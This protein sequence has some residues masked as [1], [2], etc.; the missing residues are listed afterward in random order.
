MQTIVKR[1]DLLIGA[2]A[3]GIA[4]T[5]SPARGAPVAM[6]NFSVLARGLMA[7][8]GPKPQADG[9]VLVVEMARGTL[10][11]VMPDHSVQVVARLGGSPNG[12]AIGPDGAAYV[13][14]DGGFAFAKKNGLWQA[15]GT[16]PHYIGGSIQR[17][18][19][20]T[21]EFSTLYRNCGEY[22]LLAPNDLVFDPWGGLW[23]T[24]SGTLINGKP[25]PGWIYWARADGS[26]IRRIDGPYPVP[27]GIALSPDLRT[28]YVVLTPRREVLAYQVTGPGQVAKGADGKANAR[29]LVRQT[30]D[31][32]F[33]SMSME[34]DGTLVVA[35]L[36]KGCLSLFYPDGSVRDEVYLPDRGITNV[37][38]GGPNRQTAFVT[39]SSTGQL[40][41][42][43]WPR[44]GLRLAYQ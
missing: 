5:A 13:A 19:L 42:V 15:L 7:P 20:K 36:V 34:A 8:E 35:T 1:R 26:E 16:S 10:S 31:F 18:D 32:M 14:N 11:R 27:N 37:A 43:P 24:D 30:G 25:T 2:A 40:A 6:A 29:V 4:G 9:S 41:A 44:P 12:V 38:F 23:F 21:G 33:D 17:V 22:P 28:L 3:G 39:M